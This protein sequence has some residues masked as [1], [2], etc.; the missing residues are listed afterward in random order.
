MYKL[1][2]L[3][4][5]ETL[6]FRIMADFHLAQRVVPRAFIAILV[7]FAWTKIEAYNKV[8]FCL[9]ALSYTITWYSFTLDREGSIALL[10]SLLVSIITTFWLKSFVL[11]VFIMT[12]LSMFLKPF[13]YF[14]GYMLFKTYMDILLALGKYVFT[15]KF[16]ISS[17]LT[18]FLSLSK[19]LSHTVCVCISPNWSFFTYVNK[20]LLVTISLAQVL[21]FHLKM[22]TDTMYWFVLILTILWIYL[23]SLR[24]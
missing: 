20:L 22:F 9:H 18:D 10:S 6:F 7:F 19:L 1:N 3:H 5:S 16:E 12:I 21:A 24:H 13:V 11:T 14:Q 8:A 17:R 4:N 23:R 15:Y 2:F